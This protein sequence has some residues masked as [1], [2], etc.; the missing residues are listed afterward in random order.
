M[1]W[2]QSL[3]SPP[4]PGALGPKAL[5]AALA[6]ALGLALHLCPKGLGWVRE[7]SS[8]KLCSL[9]CQARQACCKTLLCHFTGR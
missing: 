3:V 5:R 9:G 2:V 6:E 4:Q 8:L 7:F 1:C